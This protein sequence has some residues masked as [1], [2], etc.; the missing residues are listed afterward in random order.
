MGL[1]RFLALIA[2]VAFVL[3]SLV[4]GGGP[5]GA[6]GAEPRFSYTPAHGPVFTTIT[7]SNAGCS[8]SR[9]GGDAVFLYRAS[10][11]A[12]VGGAP[13]MVHEF[14]PWSSR[15]DFAVSHTLRTP[16]LTTERTTPGAYILALFCALGPDFR[17]DERGLTLPSDADLVQPFTIDESTSGAVVS[18]PEPA[19]MLDTRTDL[20]D[21]RP[22]LGPVLPGA[23]EHLPMTGH[24]G[25]PAEGVGAVVLN[26]SVVEPAAAGYLT[27]Y[28]DGA[29]RPS[30]SNLSFAR[31]QTV[32]TLVIAPVGADGKVAVFNRSGGSTHLLVDVQGFVLAGTATAAGAL[33]L[34][35][36]TR[37]LDTR[38]GNAAPIAPIGPKAATSFQV[39]GRGGVPADGVS[40]AVVS[41]TATQPTGAG[42]ITAYADGTVRPTASNLNYVG[43]QTL[44]SLVIAPVG[45][46]GRIALFN[47]S[48]GTT[49]V[50]ADVLGFFHAGTPTA[51]GTFRAQPPIRIVDTRTGF[52]VPCCPAPGPVP[53]Q[54]RDRFAPQ[55]AGRGGVPASG[56]WGVFLTVTATQPTRS[57]YLTVGPVSHPAFP[58]NVSFRAGQTVAN[59][60][61]AKGEGGHIGFYNASSGYTHV[62]VDVAGAVLSTE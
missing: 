41:V 50:I 61:L 15:A 25:I 13:Q 36:P 26:V 44:S 22:A 55:V 39:T 54:P 51:P 43:G 18:L 17:Y 52:G 30:T 21:I 11:N 56:Y 6:A 3:G 1:R 40:A 38:S 9:A 53:A 19:R 28:P 10:D 29:T 16:S 27:V 8:D 57:G 37:L 59:L 7:I 12:L 45:A 20:T 14:V 49:H 35:P 60:V 47:G 42:F 4:T 62:T 33:S 5:A 32:A 46:N 2:G 58:S 48:S 31:G 34:L 24:D 23:T